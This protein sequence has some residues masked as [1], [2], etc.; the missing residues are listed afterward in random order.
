MDL[1]NLIIFIPMV[2]II[3]GF[4]YMNFI[5]PK[6]VEREEKERQENEEKQKKLKK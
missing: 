4:V 6:K 2:L 1:N 3:I 5:F